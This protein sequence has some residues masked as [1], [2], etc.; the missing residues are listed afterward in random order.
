[1]VQGTDNIELARQING[2]AQ[3]LN[4][5]NRKMGLINNSIRSVSFAVWAVFFLIPIGS[6]AVFLIMIG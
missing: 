1:M 5:T 6:F 3:Q 2:I 4:E